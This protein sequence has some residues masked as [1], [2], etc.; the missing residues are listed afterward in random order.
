MSN[1]T[2]PAP[3]EEPVIV[4]PSVEP[5]QLTK[6]TIQF[7]IAFALCLALATSLWGDIFGTGPDHPDY[8]ESVVS[9]LAM[10]LPLALRRARPMM[11]TAM[12]GIAGLGQIILLPTP[13]WAVVAVPVACYSVAYGVAGRESRWVVVLGGIGSALGPL[14]WS[15]MT[16]TELRTPELAIPT[17]GPLIA[18]CLGGVLI[19]YLLGRRDRELVNIRRER[20]RAAATRHA[21]QIARA[22]EQA[23]MASTKVRTEIA[24]E[25]HDVVAHSLSVIIVQANGGKALARKKPEAAAQ[26][27]ETIAATGTEALT[28]MRRIVGVLRDGP[29][30]T[31][32][33]EY[34]PAPGLADIPIMVERAGDRVNLA[35]TGTQ[36]EVSAAVG[37][38]A[39]RVVQEAI[40]NVL[41]HA[42][43]TANTEVK[44]NYLPSRIDIEVRDDGLGANIAGPGAGIIKQ[45]GSGYGLTGMA[46]RVTAMGGILTAGPA[47][48]GGWRVTASIPTDGKT[49]QTESK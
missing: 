3:Y 38:T 19:P 43:E 46:E 36:P 29:A 26:V 44:L 21:E 27:L 45:E 7:D 25:L 13:T 30:K 33:A 39:Y 12:M 32:S 10:V 41:K 4:A 22:R 47:P 8:L 31:S 18:L 35:I 48:E 9:S 20:E 40:T 15:T 28:E 1:T 24:R 17:V 2:T 34:T 16:P 23:Q 11:M 37:V 14:R 6:R 49:I 42:G 5:E